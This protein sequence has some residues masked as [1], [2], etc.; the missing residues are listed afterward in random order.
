[1]SPPGAT[2]V[3]PRG[4]PKRAAIRYLGLKRRAFDKLVGE[5]HPFR[6]GTSLLY[7]VRDLDLLFDRLK[8]SSNREVAPAV[9]PDRAEGTG[10]RAAP[11]GV[12]STADRRPSEK[13]VGKWVVKAASTRTP[14]AGGESIESTAVNA[15]R[16][17]STRI[18]MRKP[19]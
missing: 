4:L 14:E 17:V 10:G 3:R 19:G 16:A 8:A 6:A 15:F 13:G 7:D 9:A 12:S 2:E 5:L 18:R 1:M 11:P